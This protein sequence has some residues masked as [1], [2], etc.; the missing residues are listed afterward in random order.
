[1]RTPILTILFLMQQ[2]ITT[3]GAVPLNLNQ[4]PNSLQ[5]CTMIKN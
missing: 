2:V 3:L 4:I 1:M 5:Y